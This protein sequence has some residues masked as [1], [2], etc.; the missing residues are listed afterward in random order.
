MLKVCLFVC[1]LKP[2][3]NELF[4]FKAFRSSD[5]TLLEV[6]KVH[7]SKA[8][9]GFYI[10]PPQKPTNQKRAFLFQGFSKLWYKFT[11]GYQGPWVQIWCRIL[12]P[13]PPPPHPWSE[14]NQSE[15]S[16]D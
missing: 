16:I 4:Y 10:R 6:I 3:R 12:Y 7:E 8:D 9:V 2:I 5:I 1:Q 11:I 14:A 15:D 13:T